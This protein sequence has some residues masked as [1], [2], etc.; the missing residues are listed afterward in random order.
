[1]DV[2]TAIFMNPEKTINLM[3][4]YYNM[5]K[6]QK[7]QLLTKYFEEDQAKKPCCKEKCVG[8]ALAHN[9]EAPPIN[10]IEE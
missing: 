9:T 8:E 4:H 6:K 7:L 1:M 5:K 2:A 10:L 3:Q